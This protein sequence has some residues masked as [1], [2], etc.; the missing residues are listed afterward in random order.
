ML[1]VGPRSLAVGWF[2]VVVAIGRAGAAQTVPGPY[3]ETVN[4]EH[5]VVDACL[6]LRTSQRLSLDNQ[7]TDVSPSRTNGKRSPTKRNSG[8]ITWRRAGWTPVEVSGISC[9]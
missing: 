6:V 5:V 8:W 3:E 9:Y 2:V 1:G 4:R 7:V